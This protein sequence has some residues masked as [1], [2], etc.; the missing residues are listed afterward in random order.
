MDVKREMMDYF[1]F[2]MEAKTYTLHTFRKLNFSKKKQ[3]L[4]TIETNNDLEEL[5]EVALLQNQVK[6]LRFQ[7]KLGKEN[8]HEFMKKG[9]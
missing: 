3:L 6:D 8:F 7:D 2:V 1:V 9:I 5:E 4:F